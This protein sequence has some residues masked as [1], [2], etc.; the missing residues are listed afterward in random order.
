[1]I[2]LLEKYCCPEDKTV[3]DL[4][5]GS[6][7]IS[8][9]I[10]CKKQTKI[11]FNEESQPHIVHDLSVNIPLDDDCCEIVI[12][13]EILEHIYFSK[14]FL[15]EIKR[16]L[17]K[18]GFLMLSVPNMCFLLYR[19]AWLL[20]IVPPFAAK[21]DYT[22]LPAGRPGGHVR[23]YSFKE[24]EKILINLNFDIIKSTTNGIIYKKLYVPH[25]LIP[26]TFGQKIIILAKNK[27]D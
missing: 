20:G 19:I 11:D 9:Y 6:N 13:G 21:A 26:R 7:A 27:K 10:N 14:N 25:F 2:T 16:I 23:D 3:V 22:Y 12:A 17:R 1:M 8:D 15:L 24:L 18:D 4:G 5:A